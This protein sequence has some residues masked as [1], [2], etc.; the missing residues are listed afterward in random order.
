MPALLGMATE[1][2]VTPGALSELITSPGFDVAGTLTLTGHIDARDLSQMRSLPAEIEE[3]NLENVAVDAWKSQGQKLFERTYTDANV[4]P[5]YCFFRTPY[6]RVILP[7]GISRIETGAFAGSDIQSIAL[8]EGITEIADYAF[9]DCKSLREVALP[10]TLKKIGKSAFGSC[11]NLISIDMAETL[12]AEIPDGCFAG[13]SALKAATL[14]EC[15]RVIGK[16]A[17]RGTA[18]H[19]LELQNV[20]ELRPYA[21]SGMKALKIANIN[22]AAKVGEGVFMDDTMLTAINGTPETIPDFFAA[23]CGNLDARTTDAASVG[24]YAFANSAASTLIL[25]ASLAKIDAGAFHSMQ[26]L[27]LITAD[28]L[29][30]NIPEV[31][32]HAFDGISRPDITLYVDGD[33]YDLWKQNPEWG[34]FNVLASNVTNTDR[35]ASANGIS[36]HATSNKLDIIAPEI[37]TEVEI[38]SIHGGLL[39]AN[40]G[41]NTKLSLNISD[42]PDNIII[43]AVKTENISKSVKLMK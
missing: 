18:I 32:E 36:I 7:K 43:V 15:T 38:Y 6:A 2:T 39:H 23:N 37:I 14:S 41:G 30:G 22:P 5:P 24:A 8:P 42:I 13:C 17:F 21:L 28:L 34:Q 1:L 35:L 9:Y 3:L 33:Y 11:V 19:T 10:T 27:N 29:K 4:L 31:S 26:N 16:E 40:S 25:G 12:V 20:D